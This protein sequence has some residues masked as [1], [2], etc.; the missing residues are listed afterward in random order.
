MYQFILPDPP[1]DPLTEAQD[2]ERAAERWRRVAR[3]ALTL[4]GQ[5]AAENEAQRLQNIARR[6]FAQVAEQRGQ[7]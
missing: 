2:A 6:F 1:V 7:R 4:E 5:I 3:M